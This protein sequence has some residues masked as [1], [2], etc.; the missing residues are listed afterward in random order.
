MPK[1]MSAGSIRT[2]S[3]VVLTRTDLDRLAAQAGSMDL[4]GWKPRPGRP[5]L[6]ANKGATN[7]PPQIDVRVPQ[8]LHRRVADRASH[9]GKTVSQV[10]RVLLESYAETSR[11]EARTVK[12]DAKRVRRTPPG[13]DPTVRR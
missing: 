13:P 5:S 9:E 3:G 10:V 7:T 4:T 11:D 8:A 2:K 1:P 12:S 6:S